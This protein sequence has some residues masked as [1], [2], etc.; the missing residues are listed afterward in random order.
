MN[1]R[2]LVIGAN[3]FIGLHLVSE[4]ISN[5]IPVT[6]LVKH[7]APT[8]NL[9]KIGCYNIINTNNLNDSYVV[10]QLLVSKPRYVVNCMWEKSKN[11]TLMSLKNTQMLIDLVNLTQEINSE[12]FINLGTYQ[13]YGVYNENINETKPALPNTSLGKLKYAHCLTLLE[14]AKSYNI[15]A[16]HLRLAETYSSNKPESFIF[17]SL[18][19]CISGKKNQSFSFPNKKND[20][21]Y[22]SDVCRAI[23]YLI[24]NN[25]SGI[26]NVGTGK[27]YPNKD[28]VNMIMKQSHSTINLEAYENSENF[29]LDINKIYKFT[30][31][32]PSISIWDG[33][34]LLLQ[35]EKFKNPKTLDNFT[36]TIRS[37][38]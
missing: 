36:S 18:I 29:A 23:I 20:Y 35:E 27:S 9:K 6:A 12:G 30:G 21:I 3:G 33:I 11:D 22:V 10:R 4:L 5:K 19:K 14:I 32:K 7:N 24:K 26:F 28:L 13:E 37:L 8:T 1:E 31:W 38:Y 17:K 2:V 25:A 15:K 16:C 34:S